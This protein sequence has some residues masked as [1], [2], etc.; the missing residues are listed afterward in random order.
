MRAPRRRTRARTACG[1]RWSTDRHV[2]ANR[3][4]AL[5]PPSRFRSR[6][7]RDQQCGRAALPRTVPTNSAE[8]SVHRTFQGLGFRDLGKAFAVRECRTWWKQSPPWPLMLYLTLCISC[9]LC[10]A[11]SVARTIRLR[12][13][14]TEPEENESKAGGPAGPGGSYWP[15]VCISPVACLK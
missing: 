13:W 6:K 15:L 10:F 12:L 7:A 9:C 14:P 3:P 2:A 8:Q 5:L 4:S 11:C 1:D